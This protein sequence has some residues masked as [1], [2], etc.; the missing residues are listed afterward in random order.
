MTRLHTRTHIGI[1]VYDKKMRHGQKG[2]CT[3]C[4]LDV[5]VV[6]R[7]ST[8]VCSNLSEALLRRFHYMLHAPFPASTFLS[9]W[10]CMYTIGEP[11]HLFELMYSLGKSPLMLNCF[12]VTLAN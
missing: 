11:V 9:V 4:L 7:P 12:F 3:K 8:F 5:S 2:L 10:F 1:Y 6:A